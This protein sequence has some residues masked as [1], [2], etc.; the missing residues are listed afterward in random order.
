MIFLSS[1]IL[2]ASW[3]LVR[4]LPNNVRCPSVPN[5]R[6][7]ILSFLRRRIYFSEIL[8]FFCNFYGFCNFYNNKVLINFKKK[9]WFKIINFFKFDVFDFLLSHYENVKRLL[10][11][12]NMCKYVNSP[13]DP[14]SILIG[15]FCKN[16]NQ[17]LNSAIF[18]PKF[19]LKYKKELVGVHE[20]WQKKDVNKNVNLN[21]K[22]LTLSTI[23]IRVNIFVLITRSVYLTYIVEIKSKS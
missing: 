7:C 16:F 22:R 3:N 20:N 4:C 1:L 15:Y 17:F 18:S 23:S 6:V 2:F 14:I 9:V 10:T 13:N 11:Q 8:W 19:S 12:I 5:V 21:V